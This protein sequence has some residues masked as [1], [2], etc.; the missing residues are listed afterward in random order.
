MA[1]F[2]HS[3]NELLKGVFHSVSLNN[4]VLSGILT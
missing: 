1:L 2:E 3:L 4:H